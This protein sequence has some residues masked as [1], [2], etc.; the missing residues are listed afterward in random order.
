MT[1]SNAHATSTTKTTKAATS[2]AERRLLEAIWSYRAGVSV[3]L[4]LHV[5]RFALGALLDLEVLA[6]ADAEGVGEDVARERLGLR[7]QAEHRVVV[8]LPGV[9]DAALRSGQ[10]LLQ[11]EEVGVGLE[12]GIRLGDGEQG[13]EG[14]SDGVLGLGLLGRALGVDGVGA[15]L[16]HGLER[17]ALVTGVA[18]HRLDQVG[19]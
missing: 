2:S 12:V 16:G 8:E 4:E 14:T 19:D 5:G 9:G 15:G 10:L 7:V 11:V 1:A 13:F 6:L 3:C 18:L 17:L